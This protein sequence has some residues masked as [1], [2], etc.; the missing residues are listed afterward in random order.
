MGKYQITLVVLI[1][2]GGLP[3]M[4]YRPTIEKL[5]L[6]VLICDRSRYISD[7]WSQFGL[8]ILI[9]CFWENGEKRRIL[10]DTGWE[11]EPL[12]HNM[13]KLD[14]DI[15]SIDAVV[16]SHCHYDHTGGLKK[17]IYNENSRFKL[18]AHSDITR[19][20]YSLKPEIHY[21]GID[22]RLI[23]E[24]PRDR[25]ALLKDETEIYHKIWITG[26]IPR[27]TDFEKPEEDVFVLKD[28]K[29]IEDM[30]EDDISLLFD[31]G[32][33]G[34][35]VISGCSHAGIINI[36]NRSMSITN[37]KKIKGIVG[38]FHL[39]DLSEE[40]RNRTI[41]EMG[42]LEIEQIWSGHCTGL[43]AEHLLKEKFKVRHNMFYTGDTIKFFS[44]K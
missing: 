33:E 34:L 6:K 11:S 39:I 31:F 36:L 25:L 38:G 4:D 35:V 18:F 44:K 17:L 30:E 8:S 12:L 7:L 16:L 5:E 1:F 24:L 32:Q 19:P 22:E 43:E 26:T 29:L 3:Y 20:V 15:G 23:S 41:E 21:I 10:F 13:K 2:K 14:I 37:T 9:D 27:V 40:V 28:G 42:N